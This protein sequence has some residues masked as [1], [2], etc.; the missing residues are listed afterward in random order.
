MG[1]MKEL[2]YEEQEQV[3]DAGEI[4]LVPLDGQCPTCEKYQ[5]GKDICDQCFVEITAKDSRGG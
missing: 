5:E 3:K 2:F 1:K 4:I